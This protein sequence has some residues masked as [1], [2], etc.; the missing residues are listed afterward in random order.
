MKRL[1]L[2]NWLLTELYIYACRMKRKWQVLDYRE[3]GFRKLCRCFSSLGLSLILTPKSHHLVFLH[4]RRSKSDY[5]LLP[6]SF[7]FATV[8]FS[9][10][11]N[12]AN[13]VSVTKASIQLKLSKLSESDSV[14]LSQR[15]CDRRTR[16]YN[17]SRSTWL[18]SWFEDS[19]RVARHLIIFLQLYCV[20]SQHSEIK[21]LFFF[22][23]FLS[24]EF[25]FKKASLNIFSDVVA[26]SDDDHHTREPSSLRTLQEPTESQQR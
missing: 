22:D 6:F 4:T 21:Y 23:L 17:S 14:S 9:S 10:L 5:L 3:R 12:F 18:R 15:N 7:P 1:W 20:W 25:I 24:E 8:L 13:N 16:T 2:L 26:H 11:R 19:N